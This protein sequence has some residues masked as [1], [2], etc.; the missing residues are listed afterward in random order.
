M[1]HQIPSGARISSVGG[2]PD[3][4]ASLISESRR[5]SEVVRSLDAVGRV[6]SCP[7]WSVADLTWH[8][9][10][11]QQFWAEIAGRLLQDPDEAVKIERPPD[12]ELADLF[13]RES[14][15][16]VEALQSSPPEAPCWSW[17]E[18]G[19]SIGWV[20]RRQA[21]EALIHRAD[22][23]LAAGLKPV[24]DVDMAADG[25]DE[26]FRSFYGGDAPE[27]AKVIPD[28]MTVRIELL[29]APGVWLLALGRFVGTSP[30]SG[31]TYDQD[32]LSLAHD[33]SGEAD[34][35]VRGT[36]SDMDLW[37]WGRGDVTELH[38]DGDTSLSGRVR[39]II[40]SST[41]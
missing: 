8:L 9:A 40:A 39:A 29:D 5:F 6:P 28:G 21:N 4:V 3:Y 7:D 19:H 18:K 12:A 30:N 35:V 20:R 41:Q 14:A 13:D 1:Q 11:V 17:D 37:L 38:M 27:W 16:L 2:M 34:L 23:E 15:R 36:A 22:A 33:S 10:E 31:R 32:D 24:L 26:L 25:V